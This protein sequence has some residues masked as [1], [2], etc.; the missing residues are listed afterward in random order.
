MTRKKETKEQPLFPDGDI[1]V[2]EKSAEEM[3]IDAY[4]EAIGI[5]ERLDV[6]VARA[7]MEE[8]ISVEHRGQETYYLKHLPGYFLNVIQFTSIEDCLFR[9]LYPNGEPR[10]TVPFAYEEAMKRRNEQSFCRSGLS[11]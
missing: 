4:S 11:C 3:L 7:L 1:R 2:R 9:R 6:Q 10:A 8:M 5:V